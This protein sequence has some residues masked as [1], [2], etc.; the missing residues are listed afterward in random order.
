MTEPLTNPK[1]DNHPLARVREKM[2]VYDNAGKKLGHV[3]SMFMGA[4]A[5]AETPGVIPVEGAK[6]EAVADHSIVMDVAR[7]FTDDMP[8]VLRN[9]LR[10]NGYIHI[11]GG[12]L[13]GDRYALREHIAAV[14]GD[15]VRLNIRG[16][17]L[18]GE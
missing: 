11:R 4:V 17:E 9:R 15:R 2:E 10:H 12:L 6:L 1:T 14:E 7:V 8:E 13:K 5:D 18:I 16:N 3:Q